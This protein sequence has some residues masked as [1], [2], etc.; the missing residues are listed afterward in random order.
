MS[1][2]LGCPLL[3]PMKFEEW[4]ICFSD[5]DVDLV[6]RWSFEIDNVADVD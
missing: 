3:V 5:R 6:E 2:E 4:R 1:V